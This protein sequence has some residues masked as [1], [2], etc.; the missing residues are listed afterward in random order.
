MPTM[1][2]SPDLMLDWDKYGNIMR[3]I[4]RQVGQGSLT[5]RHLQALV[6]HRDPFAPT[7]ELKVFKSIKLGMDIPMEYVQKLAVPYNMESPSFRIL[8][9]MKVSGEE[10]MLDLVRMTLEQLGFSS[11]GMRKKV[12]ERILEWGGELVP[13]EAA[14]ALALRHQEPEDGQQSY[15]VMEPVIDEHEGPIV[16]TLSKDGNTPWLGFRQAAPEDVW[17]DPKDR[18]IFAK[19]RQK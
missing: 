14:A 5:L 12:F 8:S 3:E 2:V 1:V 4:H 13:T 19:P 7:P 6:E 15:F 10:V 9:S 16:L 18:V 11:G 17:D